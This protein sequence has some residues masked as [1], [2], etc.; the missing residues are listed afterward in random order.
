MN[1]I[2][3]Y[4]LIG[5]LMLALLFNFAAIYDYTFDAS[6]PVLDLTEARDINA[7]LLSSGFSK[8][9]GFFEKFRRNLEKIVSDVSEV[10]SLFSPLSP[11]EKQ[12]ETDIEYFEAL[13]ARSLAYVEQNFSGLKAFFYKWDLKAIRE[14]TLTPNHLI[15]V[16]F[17]FQHDNTDIDYWR[18]KFN[19]TDDDCKWLHEYY[20]KMLIKHTYKEEV[21]DF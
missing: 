3:A 17:H 14:A 19:W 2:T 10:F 11:M 1:K 13:Y 5:C 20:N 8:I 4:I 9:V 21:F 18:N 16:Y 12:T 15:Y 6:T 7:G